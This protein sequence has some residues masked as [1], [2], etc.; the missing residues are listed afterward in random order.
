M[1]QLKSEL[2]LISKA[3]KAMGTLKFVWSEIKL[4]SAIPANLPLSRRE[5]W[6]VNNSDLKTLDTFYYKLIRRLL[7]TLIKRTMEEDYKSERT[8]KSFW[9]GIY[10]SCAWRRILLKNTGRALRQSPKFLT[11]LSLSLRSG[12]ELERG[13][14]FRTIKDAVTES[15]RTFTPRMPDTGTFEHLMGCAKLKNTW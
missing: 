4:F 5:V 2:G 10:L 6:S 7:G 12:R 11:T 14:P 15:V 9:G 1:M 13:K 3:I 8:R